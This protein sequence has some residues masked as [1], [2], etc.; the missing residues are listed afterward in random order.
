MRRYGLRILCIVLAAAL[1]A[2][3]VLALASANRRTPVAPQTTAAPLSPDR[4]LENRAP[5]AGPSTDSTE[6]SEPTEPET[7]P[8]SEPVTEPATEPATEPGSEPASDPAVEPATEPVTSPDDGPDGPKPTPEPTEPHIVTDLVSRVWTPQ[9]LA[10]GVLQF[11]AYAVGEG[12]LSLRVYWKETTASA[13]NGTRLTPADGQNFSVRMTLNKNYQFILYL[14]RDGQQYGQAATFYVSYR[15]ARADE[16]HPEV[17]I[18]PVIRTNRDGVTAPI[19]TSSFTLVVTARRGTDGAPIY[20]DH[21]NVRLDGALLTNPTGSAASGYEYVLALEPPQR[22]DERVYT[23]TILAWD[24]EGNS[25]LRTLELVYQPVS[26]GDRLGSATVRIDAT[27][28]GLGIVDSM[29]CELRQGDTAAQTLLQVLEQ[30]GYDQVDYDGTAKKNGGFYLLRL[31]RGDLLYGASIDPRLWTLILRDGITLTAAPGTDSLGEHDYTW[32]AGW[33][34]D[35]NGYYPGKGLSEWALG[36][37]DVLTLRFTLAWGKDID[38]YG[39]TGGMYG[40]LSGYCGIWRDGAFYP[41]EHSYVETARVEPT[42]TEDGYVEQTCEKCG[43]VVRT[44]LPATGSPTEPPTDPPTEPPVDPTEPTD[45]PAEPPVDPTE[46]TDPPAEPPTNPPASTD[47]GE[48]TTSTGAAR[49]FCA[50][51]NDH[52][53]LHQPLKLPKGAPL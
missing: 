35:V 10:D 5:M 22:G 23:V 19:K 42:E 4:M 3:A 31:W 8:Q 7:Q 12:S 39:A 20:A 32:G 52:S 17:G 49:T 37:G 6:P 43:E 45:P 13:N 48:P 18:A 16:D 15:A 29:T 30:C 41:L 24:D 51:L 14:Y 21:L 11:Y 28:V 2:G 38:G 40:S 46:P 25:A 33:M 26:E 9:E 1:L 50:F 47:P 36:D 44:V 34:Y 27:T 53:P